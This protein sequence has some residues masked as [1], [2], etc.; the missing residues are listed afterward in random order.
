M[1]DI[2]TQGLVVTQRTRLRRERRLSIPGA[3]V[4]E[5]GQTVRADTVLATAD[6]PGTADIVNAAAV[7]G[8][9]PRDVPGRLA[10]K[11]GDR[12]VAGELLGE[13]TGFLGLFKSRCTSPIS[14]HVESVS[15]V[16]GQ[17]V[18]RGEPA[19][20]ELTAY[21]DGR[22]AEVFP[23]E[24]AA[25]EAQGSF[26]QG[27]FGVGGEA[28]GTLMVLA[29]D[30]AHRPDAD[31]L[32][33]G[34]RGRI[35]VCGRGLSDGWVERVAGSGVRGIV[36]AG[37]TD[38]ALRSYLGFDLGGAITGS[39]RVPTLIVTEGFG[40][41]PMAPRTFEVLRSCDGRRASV[42][43]KTQIRAGV[44]RPEV[45]VAQPEAERQ[46]DITDDRATSLH[47]GARV[48]ATR[49]PFFGRLGT[50]SAI[51]AEPVLLET[52]ASV[53]AVELTF[54]DGDKALVPVSNVEAV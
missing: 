44:I 50:V 18:V 43:G 8:I 34:C 51:P 32:D 40:D 19:S 38:R 20:V 41:L 4:V 33:E 6:L 3:V 21:V 30:G 9:S 29:D 13:S 35:V 2:Y 52:E 16:T 46:D 15:A 28:Y 31:R 45:F 24:G 11:E 48:R 12:I 25:V 7:L 5:V 22:V 47:A 54:E 37:I 17:V 42:N 53:R 26:L 10:K 27:I 14:G 49:E 23:D 39:E 1:G 36:V